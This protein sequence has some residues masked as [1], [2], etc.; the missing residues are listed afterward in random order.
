MKLRSLTL[1]LARKKAGSYLEEARR[2]MGSGHTPLAI[3]TTVCGAKNRD[4]SCA[5]TLD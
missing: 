3:G 2:A 5:M 4:F 1:V